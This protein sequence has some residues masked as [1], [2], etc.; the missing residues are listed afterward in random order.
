MT[1]PTN[2]QWYAIYTK[3]N[4]E[5][6]LHDSIVI[7][8]NESQQDITAYLPLTMQTRRWSDRIRKRQVPLFSNY[9]FVKHDR[10][11]FHQIKKM[12]GFAEYV[13]FGR[14]PS[15]IP[16]S[17][18]NMIE[19]ILAYQ[20][21]LDCIDRRLVRGDKVRISQGPLTDYQ[22][23]L[24]TDAQGSKVAIEVKNLNQCM[25]VQVPV[26]SLIRLS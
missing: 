8:S 13:R 24:M 3:V 2:T 6:K 5:R 14:Y 20:Q 15:I 19:T 21:Q 9:L 16:E 12:P 11:A 1:D 23:V 22:G 10:H 18:I 17:Q 25:K 7:Y 4:A 26:A